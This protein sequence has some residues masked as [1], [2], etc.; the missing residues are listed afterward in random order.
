M[1]F[2]WPKSI[3]RETS[4]QVLVVLIVLTKYDDEKVRKVLEWG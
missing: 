1:E 2:T 4:F 3:V